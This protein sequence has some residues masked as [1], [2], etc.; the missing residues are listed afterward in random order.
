MRFQQLLK[1]QNIIEEKVFLILKN[2][3]RLKSQLKR[4]QHQR[5]IKRVKIM[6]LKKIKVP[7]YILFKLSNKSKPRKERNLI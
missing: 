1:K 6:E 3:H 2:Y 4:L 7:T 5:S